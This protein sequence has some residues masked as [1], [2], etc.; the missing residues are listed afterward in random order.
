MPRNRGVRRSWVLEPEDMTGI[1]LLLASDDIAKLTGQT[2]I[3][4]A[5]VWFAG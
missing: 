4:D 2:I 3:N 5:G 1:V